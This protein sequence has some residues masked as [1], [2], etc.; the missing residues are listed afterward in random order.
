MTPRSAVLLWTLALSLLITATSVADPVEVNRHVLA[1][2]MTVLVR[3]NPAAP[4]FAVSL[5]VRGGSRFE[6]KA[7]AGATNF[8]QRVL[9]RGTTKRSGIEIAEAAED[10]GGRVEASGEVESAEVRVEGLA[11]NW[12]ALLRLLAEVVLSPAFAPDEIETQR[13]LVLSQLNARADDPFSASLDAIVR[14]L[15]GDHPYAWP[16]LGTRAALER[17]TRD[18]LIARYR[19][20]YQPDR[21]VLAVSGDVEPQRVVTLLDRLFGRLER[22]AGPR[23]QSPALPAV[24]PARRRLQRP[25]HQAQLVVGYLGPG[26]GDPAYPAIR[27]LG[28][29]LGGGMSSRLF[30][31][32]RGKHGLAY[33]VGTL[34]PY[35]SG[36][37]FIIAYTGTSAA[38][39]EAAE[40]YVM[41]EIERLRA[42]PVGAGE[43]ARA[44]AWLLGNLAL[45]R[46]TNA[47]RAW[48]LAFFE[49]VGV[50]WEFPDRYATA[51][52]AVGAD[53]VAA[54]AKRW[55]GRPTVVLLAPPA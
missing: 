5:Q 43:L 20:L 36:S 1:N 23:S 39:V 35:R 14:D 11:R 2:G 52:Q 46:R 41:R 10:L 24:T 40:R 28:A 32:L 33:S 34:T 9:L 22:S 15:Y 38:S 50:G 47:Q 6:T 30:L 12:E 8:L 55:L 4:V 29:V 54:A 7:T 48:H 17:V 27:V 26:L 16:S 42:E 45:D 53:D 25:V 44:K 3:Q 37:S 31:E 19:D 51:I 13:R 49:A 18:Q 21:M